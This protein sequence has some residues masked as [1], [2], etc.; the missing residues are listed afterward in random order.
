MARKDL[1]FGQRVIR[2]ILSEIKRPESLEHRYAQA[3]LEQA[4]ANAARRP[5]P[6][7]PMAARNLYV[8]GASI[9][10]RSQGPAADVAIGSEF[11]STLYPQFHRAPNPAG[12]W[13]YPASRDPQ[14]LQAVDKSLEDL[15]RQAIS[16]G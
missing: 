3:M 8:D 11:G 2:R 10:P 15:V 16:R 7:A 13:L 12:Y 4:K 14:T 5:T 6:Q 9:V 1:R